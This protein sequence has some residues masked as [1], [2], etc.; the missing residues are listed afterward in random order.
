MHGFLLVCKISRSVLIIIREAT[1]S[2]K[3]F[4]LPL[5]DGIIFTSGS[6]KCRMCGK[7]RKLRYAEFNSS[8]IVS[9]FFVVLKRSS[10]NN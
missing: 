3:A 7:C 5:P 6:A 9:H 4:A 2:I 10:K 8:N 1:G